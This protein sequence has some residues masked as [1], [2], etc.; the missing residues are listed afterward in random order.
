[1]NW[2]TTLYGLHC[3]VKRNFEPRSNPAREWAVTQ[4]WA[5]RCLDEFFAQGDQ[6]QSQDISVATD[7]IV[8]TGESSGSASPIPQR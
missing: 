1:M 5:D 4:A 3:Q 7:E 6:A 8:M 2:K